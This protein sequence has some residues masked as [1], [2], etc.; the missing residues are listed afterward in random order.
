MMFN[1]LEEV[2]GRRVFIQL[3]DSQL[4]K[5]WFRIFKYV[6]KDKFQEKKSK[7]TNP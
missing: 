3:N 5:L 7:T 4:N 6:L 2:T 1:N